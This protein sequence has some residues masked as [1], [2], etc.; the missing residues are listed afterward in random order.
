MSGKSDPNEFAP[1]PR[2]SAVQALVPVCILL[3]KGIWT[4]KPGVLPRSNL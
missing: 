3:T 2:L 4:S 1:K